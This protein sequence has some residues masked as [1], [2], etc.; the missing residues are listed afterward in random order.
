MGFVNSNIM[1]DQNNLDYSKKWR[2]KNK[3]YIIIMTDNYLK[4]SLLLFFVICA[5]LL[6]IELE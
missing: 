1:I 2:F 4:F 6:I 5:L 3:K